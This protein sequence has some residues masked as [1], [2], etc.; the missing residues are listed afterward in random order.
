MFNKFLKKKKIPVHN[1]KV[2]A[3]IYTP[4]IKYEYIHINMYIICI[5]ITTYVEMYKIKIK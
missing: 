5:Y 1:D 3:Y 2:N 4:Q